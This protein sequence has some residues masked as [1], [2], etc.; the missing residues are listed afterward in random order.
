MTF[1]A[2][3]GAA[4]LA[5]DA[6]HRV[7]PCPRTVFRLVRGGGLLGL[8][9]GDGTGQ[10]GNSRSGIPQVLGM[11]IEMSSGEPVRDQPA[12]RIVQVPSRALRS[13]WSFGGWSPLRR[14]PRVSRWKRTNSS[15]LSQRRPARQD[16]GCTCLG[17]GF[18]VHSPGH[19]A[20]GARPGCCRLKNC[21]AGTEDW[22]LCEWPTDDEVMSIMAA[23]NAVRRVRVRRDAALLDEFGRLAGHVV[24]AGGDP[25]YDERDRADRRR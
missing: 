4:A 13:L 18:D 25:G 8:V 19:H 3:N 1:S 14:F 24:L 2:E 5:P 21:Y 15:R 6:S 7:R 17:A 11:G 9:L 10:S 16:P 22:R 12:G 20:R 23:T